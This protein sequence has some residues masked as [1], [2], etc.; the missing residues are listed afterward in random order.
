MTNSTARLSP[1]GAQE[2]LAQYCRF[3]IHR[4]PVGA[5]IRSDGP[6]LSGTIHPFRESSDMRIILQDRDFKIGLFSAN[7]RSG[8]A[9]TA[10]AER[11]SRSLTRSG[12]RRLMLAALQEGSDEPIG[13]AAGEFEIPRGGPRNWTRPTP[14]ALATAWTCSPVV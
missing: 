11:R 9:V 4:S 13:D 8:L 14:S 12:Q 6:T 1:T 5:G 10:T 2:R 7:C 3:V